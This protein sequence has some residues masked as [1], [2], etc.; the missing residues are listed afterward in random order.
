MVDLFAPHVVDAYKLGHGLQ[1]PK[2]LTMK[3]SNLTP[4]SHRLFKGATGYDGKMVVFGTQ[5]GW[6]EIVELWDRSF[7]N[8]SK[9]K[10]I[11]RYKRRV[12]N[13]IGVDMIPVDKMAE[14]HDLGYLP[15]S[16][17]AITE[18]FRVPMK[19]PIL[20]VEN[21]LPEFGW[22]VN[23]LETVIS[24]ALWMSSTNA[25]IAY[26][27]HRLL[28]A[29]AIKT[30]SDLDGV[31]FQGH[32]FS[33]RGM[34][35][36]EQAA[37]VGSAHLT[38]FS[39]T[40]T[41]SAI[42]YLEDYYFADSDRELVGVSVPAT[43]HAVSSSNILVRAKAIREEHPELSEA[44]VLL[45]AEISF[46]IDY[47]TKLHPTGIISYVADT[48]DYWGVLTEVLP[49]VFDLVK[50]REGKLV[51][52]PDSGDPV[53]IICGLK[54]GQYRRI[55]DGV[56]YPLEAWNGAAFIG[57]ADP[58]PEHVIKGSIEVLWDLFGGTTTEAGYKLLDSHIGLIYGD[59][60]TLSRA[61]AILEGLE[62]KGFAS[63]NVVF[64][65]G[66]YTYQMNTRDTFGTAMKATACEVE[67]DFIEIYKDPKTGDGLKK[68]AKG[69]LRVTL[70][71][72]EF[73]LHDQQ[74]REQMEGEDN[75]L[76]EVW[77]NGEWLVETD[78]AQ[79]RSWL[80]SG[81]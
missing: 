51:I 57:G 9:K 63:G 58:I 52:R 2:G 8:V 78:L 22:L 69:L 48:Y 46:M 50:A 37:R 47:I 3:Y 40:D 60:I 68:S 39:G 72:G 21:T 31:Q 42:D 54:E 44:D 35:G 61:E 5:G 81:L 26:E 18:G 13:T 16:L 76:I 11:G 71:D 24:S 20:T 36:P 73:I 65:I 10:A 56:A 70:E 14:L 7:F 29:Y 45:R 59:S 74:T 79:V 67:G 66:S 77:R 62:A 19:I 30:G 49:A 32:D 23:Y 34:P 75:Q 55:R 53:K 28:M 80:K 43:E 6:Q 15:L 1:D 27:Y 4:R 38:S 17:R 33:A 41:I 12:D 25:T 64:G